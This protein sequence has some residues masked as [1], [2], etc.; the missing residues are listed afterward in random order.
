MTSIG[1][2]SPPLIDVPIIV[3]VRSGGRPFGPGDWV[4]LFMLDA[5]GQ[6]TQRRSR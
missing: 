5:A 3:H 6:A 4:G 2:L 1:I